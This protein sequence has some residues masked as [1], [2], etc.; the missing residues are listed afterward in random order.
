MQEREKE[1][2]SSGGGEVFFMRTPMD[3][4]A[5]DGHLILCEYSE[6]HPTLVMCTGMA[7]KIKNYYRRPEVHV[8]RLCEGVSVLYVSSYSCVCVCI[9]SCICSCTILSAQCIQYT[10]PAQLAIHVLY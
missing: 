1:R 8:L 3:L 5:C 9:Y 6:Q 2:I 7:T 4:S 10:I